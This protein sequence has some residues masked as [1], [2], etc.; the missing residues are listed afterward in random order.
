M[1]LADSKGKKPGV[2]SGGSVIAIFPEHPVKPLDYIPDKS[3]RL[4]YTKMK[5]RNNPP[6]LK[7]RDYRIKL[8]MESMVIATAAI[9]LL[10]VFFF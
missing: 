6:R 4:N 9:L 1:H 7:L 8:L 10:V 5:S 2:I 3:I